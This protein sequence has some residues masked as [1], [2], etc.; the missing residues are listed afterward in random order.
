METSF[1]PLYDGIPPVLAV[2]VAVW[3]FQSVVRMDSSEFDEVRWK[4][5]V[6]R[7]CRAFL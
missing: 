4:V 1:S 2:R 7:E 6:S 5:D 3:S